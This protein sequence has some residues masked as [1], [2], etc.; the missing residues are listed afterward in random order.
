MFQALRFLVSSETYIEHD[1]QEKDEYENVPLMTSKICNELF[2]CD[3]RDLVAI[4][5]QIAAANLD[6]K[7]PSIETTSDAELSDDENM[8]EI[9]SGEV[10]ISIF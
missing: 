2:D 10:V 9:E 5:N 1:E 6:G 3:F 8:D 4:D 7:C